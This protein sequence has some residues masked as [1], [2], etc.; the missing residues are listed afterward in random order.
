[1][2]DFSALNDNLKD[3]VPSVNITL[4]NRALSSL[5][6]MRS[7]CQ[8]AANAYSALYAQN[9]LLKYAD[10][11][12]ISDETQSTQPERISLSDNVIATLISDLKALKEDY[13]NAIS[14]LA[15]SEA[16]SY[17]LPDYSFN[18]GAIPLSNGLYAVVEKPEDLYDTLEISQGQTVVVT[19][20]RRSEEIAMISQV[21]VAGGQVVFNH[22]GI[23]HNLL[24][25]GSRVY[26]RPRRAAYSFSVTSVSPSSV[27][28]SFTRL[29]DSSF[30][31]IVTPCLATYS[32]DQDTGLYTQSYAT[33]YGAR[34][35]LQ[36]ITVDQTEMVESLINSVPAI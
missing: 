8:T 23:W 31:N 19:F 16:V 10:N 36:V 5:S 22:S 26:W 20:E 4:L 6:S 25:T 7:K 29:A 21:I 3:F 15:R 35:A 32:R 24:F 27:S 11:G 1:M 33:G 13:V 30:D 9:Q 34:D 12:S 14:S 18:Y 28:V 2:R 17:S